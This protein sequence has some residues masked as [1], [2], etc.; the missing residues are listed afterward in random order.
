[1]AGLF[2]WGENLGEGIH[3]LG[4]VYLIVRWYG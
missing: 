3:E 2:A 4:D 1:M